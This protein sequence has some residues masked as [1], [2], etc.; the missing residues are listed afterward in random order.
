MILTEKINISISNKIISHYNKIFNNLKIGDKINIS[1]NQ[2]PIGSRQI[3]LCQCDECKSEKYMNYKTYN[4]ITNNNSEKYYCK[5]CKNIK[6]EKT[7]IDIYGFKNVFQNKKIK[8]DIKNT[9]IK[10]YGFSSASKNEKIKKKII[11]KETATKLKNSIKYYENK[12]IKI[13]NKKNDIYTIYCNECNSNFK[14]EQTILHNRIQKNINICTKCFPTYSYTTSQKQKDIEFFIR[15]INDN[16]LI[17]DRKIINPYEI[18]IYLPELKLAFEYNDVYWHNELNKPNDYHKMKS[19]LCEEKGIQLIHIWE[20]DWLYKQNIIKSMILN[21]LNK[22]PNKIYARKCVIKEVD[23]KNSKEFLNQNHIQGFIGS[24]IRLGLYFNNEL[25]SLMTFGKKRLFM[26]S[27]SYEGE[28]ELLRYC[29]KLN[30]SVI[31]G[32]SRLFQYFLKN[33]NPKQITTYADRS[34]SNGNLYKQL[35]FKFVHKTEPNYYYVVGDLRKHRFNFRKDILVKNGY[36]SNKS[37]HEIMMKRKIYRIFNA[38]NLKFIYT[39]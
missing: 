7:N 12:G 36:D 21:K 19:D 24:P 3:I 22:T 10:K 18:D 25:V 38:G 15:K 26:K 31:G 33:Y 39:S 35:G 20:D 30:T 37:E 6:T 29:N 27:S 8:D 5:K 17:S 4:Y 9:N 16:S 11:K 13:I 14:I 34:Y 32:A 1:P 23:S 2:L 28:Y